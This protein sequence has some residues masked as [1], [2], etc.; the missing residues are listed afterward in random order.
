MRCTQ[1]SRRKVGS[2]KGDLYLYRLVHLADN[3]L[4]NLDGKSLENCRLVSKAMKEVIDSGKCKYFI[5]LDQHLHHKSASGKS[6]IAEAY[7][8]W[9]KIFEG[10]KQQHSNDIVFF[11]NIIKSYLWSYKNTDHL[12]TNPLRYAIKTIE[13]AGDFLELVMKAGFELNHEVGKS[14]FLLAMGYR[15]GKVLEIL[16]DRSDDLNLNLKLKGIF[17][18]RN[19]NYTV[20]HVAC[21]EKRI[22]LLQKLF[23]KADQ[24]NVNATI[25]PYKQTAF[26]EACQVNFV[27]GVRL[28]LENA[29]TLQIDLN[30]PLDRTPLGI[31]VL[32]GHTEVVKILLDASERYVIETKNIIRTSGYYR[33]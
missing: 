7:P 9:I 4:S 17:K 2:Q 1:V 11:L 3:I 21:M 23:A 8:E 28:F 10:I 6:S 22:T 16:V 13:T 12:L 31:A 29:E 30:R 19:R 24:I 27:E 15:S 20:L 32:N 25:K 5:S 14:L 26:Y 18:D 33:T